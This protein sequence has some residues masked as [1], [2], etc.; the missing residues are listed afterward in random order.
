MKVLKKLGLFAVIPAI[1]VL[2]MFSSAAAVECL[3]CPEGAHWIDSCTAPGPDYISDQ[4]ILVGI[5]VTL[6]GDVD[7]SY[8]MTPV[9]QLK[10]RRDPPVGHSIA[11]EILN[12]EVQKNGIFVVAGI[13][14]G[15]QASN[16]SI[17]EVG[18][19]PTKGASWF[20]VYVEVR[21]VPGFPPLWNHVPIRIADTITC[22]EPKAN[23]IHFG[24]LIPLY[25]AP[26]DE[27]GVIMANIV[28]AKH[29][30]NINIIPTLSEWGLIIFALLVLSLI[31]VVATRRQTVM[32]GANGG[33]ELSATMS[34]PLFTP[35]IYVK[36][37]AV[38]M[39][40]A[41]IGLVIALAVSGTMAVRD[42]AGTLLSSAIVA[43]M[44]H[45]WIC[46]NR[47]Q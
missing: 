2:M 29:L 18:G 36:A 19:N 45:L 43:Y 40:L 35:A 9:S 28:D 21:N 24:G 5:D 27:G 17:D 7:F 33:T 11:T 30:V 6:N 14:Q 34:G 1:T 39:T 8:R 23:Y 4:E 41:G 46:R 25:D 10:V 16:G 37:L 31:T 42:V 13:E 47:K 15:Q 38:T 44:A 3:I 20:D 26:P 12:L 22:I 32:A